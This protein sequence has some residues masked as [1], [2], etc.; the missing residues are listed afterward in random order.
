VGEPDLSAAK[1]VVDDA[2]RLQ[3][4]L[5]GSVMVAGLS[6]DQASRLIERKLGERYC[7]IPM[8]RST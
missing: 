8:S 4:P 6:P 1:L 3:M 2:G 5:L 7:A